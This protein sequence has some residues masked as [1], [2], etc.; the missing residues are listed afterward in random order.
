MFKVDI[1]MSKIYHE[2]E[3]AFAH[4][5]FM[6]LSMKLVKYQILLQVVC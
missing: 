1:S 6:Y 2:V 3:N 5:I 4:S